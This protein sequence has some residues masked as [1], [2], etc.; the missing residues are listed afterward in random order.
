MELGKTRF[1]EGGMD[2][3]PNRPRFIVARAVHVGFG[4]VDYAVA[5]GRGAR[6]GDAATRFTQNRDPRAI[7]KV[8]D[9]EESRVLS[10]VLTVLVWLRVRKVQA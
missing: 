7:F 9:D 10:G 3:T 1:L 6:L 5:V 2:K 4:A 8:V